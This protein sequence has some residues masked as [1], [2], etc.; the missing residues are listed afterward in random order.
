M[1][2][3]RKGDNFSV[4]KGVLPKRKHLPRDPSR[5]GLLCIA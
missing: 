2:T 3:V 5:A 1:W 4:L